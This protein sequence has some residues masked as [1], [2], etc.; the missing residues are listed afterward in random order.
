MKQ[1]LLAYAKSKQFNPGVLGIIV[2]PFYLARRALWKG[3]VE[4]GALC[5][6]SL[7]DVGCGSKPYRRLFPVKEYIGLEIDSPLTRLRAV[8]ESYYDGE[9]FPFDP[10]RFDVVL[11]NQVLEHVFNPERFIAELNR[12]LKPNGQLILTV[13]F[14]WDEHEQPYDFARYTTF[15]L[16]ALLERQGFAVTIQR[17]TLADASVL[18]QLA[19][20]YLYKIFLPKRKVTQ[21]LLCTLVFA[22]ISAVGWLAGLI[23]PS[24]ADLFLDQIVVAEKRVV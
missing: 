12:V 5:G 6:G 4:V 11:C 14:V 10:G 18:F 7:L 24:N 17:K 19:N 8:A 1:S 15:G 9:T 23:L 20:A 22:P 2:T 21:L 16:R 13:P 3:M